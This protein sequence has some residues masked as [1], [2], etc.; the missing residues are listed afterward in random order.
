MRRAVLRLD[1]TDISGEQRSDQSHAGNGEIHK[2]R[3]NLQGERIGLGEY[4]SPRRHGFLLNGPGQVLSV[5]D[6]GFP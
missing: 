3:L 4:I 1:A 6:H 5:S 2:I